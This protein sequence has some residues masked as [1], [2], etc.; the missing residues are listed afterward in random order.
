MSD[1]LKP[2]WVKRDD[3]FL[4][5]LFRAK[6]SVY[7]KLIRQIYWLMYYIID[8]CVWGQVRRNL[9]DD[10]LCNFDRMHCMA[11]SVKYYQ[12]VKYSCDA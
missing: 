9:R 4:H 6:S 2:D 10:I 1:T 3:W 11:T 5:E 7:S 8:A 12:L